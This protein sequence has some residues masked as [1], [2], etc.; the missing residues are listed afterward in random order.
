MHAFFACCSLSKAQKGHNSTLQLQNAHPFSVSQLQEFQK[1]HKK[2]AL[3]L[4]NAFFCKR[5]S[6]SMAGRCIVW[7]LSLCTPSR[8]APWTRGKSNC[9]QLSASDPKAI[10]H[11]T[12]PQ[13]RLLLLIKCENITCQNIQISFLLLHPL[14]PPTVPHHSETPLK[15]HDFKP[16]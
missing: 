10:G 5:L 15:P 6:A 2:S 16:L 11:A 12:T 8:L 3:L 7:I 9:G 1:R 14:K 13:H 4:T